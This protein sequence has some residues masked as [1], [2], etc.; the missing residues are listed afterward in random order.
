L[1]FSSVHAEGTYGRAGTRSPWALTAL[2]P[3][4]LLVTGLAVGPARAS[5]DMAAGVSVDLVARASS[6]AGGV[7]DF[8][9]NDGT[10]LRTGDGLQLRLKS[11]VDAYVYVIAYGSSN[12][13]VIVHPFSAKAADALLRKGQSEVIPRS[14]AFLPLDGREGRETLFTIASTEPIR[15][16]AELLARIEKHGEDLSAI[17]AMLSAEFPLARRLSFKHIGARPL[18][19]VT[20]GAASASTESVDTAA[21]P[22]PGVSADPA[23]GVSLLPP[24][25]SSWSV[26]STQSFDAASAT[27]A[28]AASSAP[29]ASPTPAKTSGDAAPVAVD[30][31]AQP[32]TASAA[33]TDAGVSEARS[34]AR[35][36][37]GI[38]EHQFRGILATLPDA[39]NAVAPAAVQKT[40]K[41]QGV[42]DA[43]GSR[44]RALERAQLESGQSWP[45]GSGSG[46]NIQN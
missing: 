46:E 18:L 4:L 1:E 2:I 40:Y 16:I 23:A 32:A 28:P 25:G 42:L 20:A 44:I 34:K 15:N 5:V 31:P 22:A 27:A 26:T 11:D 39:G 12:T 37:A 19:G 17:S 45:A 9:V 14:G 8:L 21:A 38:D 30:K 6:A 43:E 35:A 24:A 3:V 13:A 29:A 10:V 41:E 33:G 7:Q 36:A